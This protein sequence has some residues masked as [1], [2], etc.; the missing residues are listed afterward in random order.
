MKVNKVKQVY[1]A[2]NPKGYRF[3]I[4]NASWW[5]S[6]LFA[7]LLIYVYLVWPTSYATAEGAPSPRKVETSGSRPKAPFKVLYSNDTTNITSCTSPFHKRG[8]PFTDDMLRATVDEAAGCDV[9]MLQPGLGWIPWWKS[10]AYPAD[11]H[12]RWF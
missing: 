4:V 7:I 11:E 8:E 2:I 3:A 6:F 1:R 10:K 9:H 5:M 12:Y